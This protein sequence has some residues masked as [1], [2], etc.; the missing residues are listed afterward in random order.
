V[1]L[2]MAKR[3][4]HVVR[5]GSWADSAS[6]LRSGARRGSHKDWLRRDPCRPPSIWWLTDAD[7]VGFRVVRPVEEYASLKGVRSWVV[8]NSPLE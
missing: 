7:F 8:R 1:F 5:G 4:S 6:R 3:F 2:P